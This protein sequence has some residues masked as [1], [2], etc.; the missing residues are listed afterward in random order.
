MSTQNLTITLEEA[1]RLL[2]KLFDEELTRYTTPE[3]REIY[4][5]LESG[6]PVFQ[7]KLAHAIADRPDS[8]PA[9]MLLLYNHQLRS[10]T[11]TGSEALRDRIRA[12]LRATPVEQV[13]ALARS[14]P[15]VSEAPRVF[16]EEILS[17]MLGALPEGA[18]VV[19]N[20]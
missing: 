7:L 17:E 12:A 4:Y 20:Q 1:S 9:E 5:G 11:P 19:E 2:P 18:V 3:L 16:L 10:W 8:T 6:T 13:L 15:P 14:N